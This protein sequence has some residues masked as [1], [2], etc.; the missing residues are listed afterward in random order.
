MFDG[1]M[2]EEGEQ[3]DRVAVDV[4][5]GEFMMFN[6][7]VCEQEENT[8]GG[9]QRGEVSYSLQEWTLHVSTP[10]WLSRSLLQ[11][12]ILSIGS[13]TSV[14]IEFHSGIESS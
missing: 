6:E 11:P 5:E 3:E 4:K 1:S 13:N 7:Q 8:D 9:R 14:P 12:N 10:T 2:A